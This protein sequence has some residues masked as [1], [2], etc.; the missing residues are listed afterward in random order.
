MDSTVVGKG[1]RDARAIATDYDVQSR[2]LLCH[3]VFLIAQSIEWQEG[4]GGGCRPACTLRVSPDS[5]RYQLGYCVVRIL[6]IAVGQGD[7]KSSYTWHLPIPWWLARTHRI[8]AL[9]GA[10]ISRG[11]DVPVTRP[12]AA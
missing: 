3:L 9:S 2:R 6:C 7:L 11:G 4:W 10:R 12:F 1:P 5:D 8:R